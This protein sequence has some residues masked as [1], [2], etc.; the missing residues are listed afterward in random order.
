[1]KEAK[2]HTEV[3]IKYFK[4]KATIVDDLTVGNI[5]KSYVY[6]INHSGTNYVLKGYRI[7]LEHLVPGNRGSTDVFL[8]G[9]R[10]IGEVFQEYYSAKTA[11]IFSPHFAKPLLLDYST[12]LVSNG[13]ESSY[14]YMEI[15]SEYGGVTLDDLGDITIKICYRGGAPCY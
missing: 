12:Q 9:V 6:K 2:I 3:D 14:M 7:Q 13:T 4:T 11:S 8:D 5:G 15:I 1:M 10:D